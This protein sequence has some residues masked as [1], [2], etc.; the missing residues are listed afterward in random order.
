MEL[1]SGNNG[2]H[3]LHQQEKHLFSKWEQ[4]M[5]HTSLQE[6]NTTAFHHNLQE[7]QVFNQRTR[8]KYQKS[9]KG[10]KTLKPGLV[11]LGTSTH[12]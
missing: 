8:T 10:A 6:I 2:Q 5:P 7:R 1:S 3:R 9:K 12:N 4:A 11:I